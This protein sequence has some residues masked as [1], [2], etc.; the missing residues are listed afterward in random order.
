[1]SPDRSEPKVRGSGWG[2]T[3]LPALIKPSHGPTPAAWALTR[4]SPGPGTGRGTRSN[5]IASGGPNSCTRQAIIDVSTWSRA[6]SWEMLFVVI[7]CSLH[8]SRPGRSHAAA[9][10]RLGRRLHNPYA[11]SSWRFLLLVRY[12]QGIVF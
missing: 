9:A 7:G 10:C 1:M 3:L 11:G 2:R 5:F 8:L 6:S 4:T 12:G